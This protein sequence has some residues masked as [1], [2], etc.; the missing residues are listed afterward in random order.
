MQTHKDVFK[1]SII[2]S[3]CLYDVWHVDVDSIPLTPLSRIKCLHCG[4]YKRK[5][6][7]G[8]MTPPFQEVK[9]KINE[10]DGGLVFVWRNDGTQPW[11]DNPEDL[12]HITFKKRIGRQL[13]GAEAG[14]SRYVQ[15]KM[16]EVNIYFLKNGYK[17]L[18]F[19]TGHCE[20]ICGQKKCPK[21]SGNLC[22][23]VCRAVYPS[24][25]SWYIDVFGLCDNLGIEWEYPAHNYIQLVSMIL[26]KKE[27]K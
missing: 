6:G 17:T 7:C 23:S 22:E 18:P 3:S 13:K 14:M 15:D 4:L 26:I 21:R 10:M 27:E 20:R 5:P 19:L 8:W 9:K 1:K 16:K 25:E 24:L 2:K 12:S 11:A